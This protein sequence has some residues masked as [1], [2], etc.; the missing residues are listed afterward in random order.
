MSYKWKTLDGDGP[1]DGR[2]DQ[3]TDTTAYRDAFSHAE[4]I[5][6]GLKVLTICLNVFSIN[7]Q[8]EVKRKRRLAN[9]LRDAV[10]QLGR[11]L[12]HHP[13]AVISA[14][15]DL[16]PASTVTSILFLTL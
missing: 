10:I 13:A 2:T 1:T 3:P 8:H 9:E 16:K 6:K 15:S 4:R 12:A 11:V 7:S 5:E 14:A